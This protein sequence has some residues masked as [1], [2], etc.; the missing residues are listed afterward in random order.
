MLRNLLILSFLLFPIVQVNCQKEK[1]IKITEPEFSGTTVFVNDTVGNGVLL[2]QQTATLEKGIVAI[3]YVVKVCCSTV[4]ADTINSQFIV[5]VPDNSLSPYDE[6]HIIKLKIE[7]SRRT[8]NYSKPETVEFKA[9]K[10]GT[11]SYLI[12][13]PKFTLG[14]YA[15]LFK[16]NNTVNLFGVKLIRETFKL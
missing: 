12:T 6:I 16:N 2:E 8:W 5:R 4:F 1:N 15:I 3:K 14:Q 10:Y 11:S 9:K 13:V 7:N